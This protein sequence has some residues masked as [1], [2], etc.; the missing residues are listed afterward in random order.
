V[1]KLVAMLSLVLL[2]GVLAGC[3]VQS[4]PAETAANTITMGPNDYIGGVGGGSNCGS[5]TNPCTITIKKGQTITFVDDKSTGT[6]HILVIGPD[7]NAKPEAGAPDFGSNG[8]TYQPGDSKATPPWN[9]VGTFDVS[10]VVHPTTM[11][12]KVTVTA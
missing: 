9:T 6:M 12:L 10:C 3:V 5:S 4:Q 7:G 8:I 2:M 11:D 1:K